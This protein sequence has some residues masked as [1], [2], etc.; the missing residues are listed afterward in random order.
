MLYTNNAHG[1]KTLN[2]EMGFTGNGSIAFDGTAE[3]F[4]AV[5]VP[6]KTDKLST[7]KDANTYL[8]KIQDIRLPSPSAGEKAIQYLV[9]A[10]SSLIKSN[11][12][13]AEIKGLERPSGFG[14]SDD[15]DHIINGLIKKGIVSKT[16]P[17]HK[18]VKVSKKTKP[19]FGM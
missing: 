7:Q 12:E 10:I 19:S 6:K 9:R 15:A 2:I 11:P 13:I 16:A 5:L 18:L 8:N 14:H 1:T 3:S 17:Q 4:R